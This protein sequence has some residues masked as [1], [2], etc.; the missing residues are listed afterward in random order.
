MHPAGRNELSTRDTSGAEQVLAGSAQELDTVE[1]GLRRTF[2]DH[3]GALT[4]KPQNTLTVPRRAASFGSRIG[5][6][7]CVG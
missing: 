6:M 1:A 3:Y 2:L 7:V 4:G 5:D